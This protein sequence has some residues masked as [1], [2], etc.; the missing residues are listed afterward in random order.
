MER[1][2]YACWNGN[3]FCISVCCVMQTRAEVAALSARLKGPSSAPAASVASGGSDSQ[4]TLTADF[5]QLRLSTAG[6][7]PSAAI[8]GSGSAGSAEEVE[9]EDEVC[10]DA[11]H[12]TVGIADSCL[13]RVQD[14][15]DDDDSESEDDE[16][17][18]DGEFLSFNVCG[19][20][21]ISCLSSFAEEDD[22]GLDEDDMEG[23]EGE[24]AS[25]PLCAFSCLLHSE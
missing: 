8:L 25:Q 6:G 14:D 23:E 20:K 11:S 17:E 2:S 22:L 18:G 9:A 24:L 19:C 21:R 3:G 7:G 10:V 13:L 1:V 5:A 12:V 4:S 15:D 16:D